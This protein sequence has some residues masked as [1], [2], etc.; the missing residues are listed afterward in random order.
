MAQ[1]TSAWTTKNK[2]PTWCWLRPFQLYLCFFFFLTF[3]CYVFTDNSTQ[4]CVD[5]FFSICGFKLYA[6]SNGNKKRNNDSRDVMYIHATSFQCRL[7]SFVFLCNYR[8]CFFVLCRKWFECTRLAPKIDECAAHHHQE[9]S[10]S[11][12]FWR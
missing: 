3:S 7:V 4:K 11:F 9:C 6:I 1:S 8:N 2:Y 12:H 10:V 5:I